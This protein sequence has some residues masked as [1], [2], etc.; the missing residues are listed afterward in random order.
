MSNIESKEQ[1]IELYPL[2]DSAIVV[3]FGKVINP[4]TN[5]KVK[6]LSNYLDGHPFPGMVEYVPSFTTVTV[7]YDPLQLHLAATRLTPY[8]SVR[9]KLEQI[10]SSLGDEV[11]L[12]P[13]RVEI[14]VCYGGE[15]GPDLAYVGEHNGM[16]EEEIIEIHSSSEYLVY[17]IGF[18]P[19][20]P[21]LGGMDE[22]IA[23]PRRSTPRVAIPAG[24]VGIGGMQ[25]GIY[26]IETPG[27]WQL[28]GRTPL[29][30]FRPNDRTP[31]LLQAGDFI[32]FRPIS[33]EAYESWEEKNPWG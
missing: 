21:Y 3:R 15:F 30:L 23:T 17:V 20:F 6:N 2:G 31:S 29:A 19:G 28:I 27:G 24:T 11:N 5:Q 8:E 7:Y 12:T 9:S 14:P 18:A 32:T 26:P 4:E 1:L 25:T 22:R 33:R 16:T 13:R 10:I